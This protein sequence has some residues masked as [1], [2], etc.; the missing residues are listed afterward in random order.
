MDAP[1]FRKGERVLVLWDPTREWKQAIITGIDGKKSSGE[2]QYRI[3]YSE[4]NYEKRIPESKIRSI[5][6]YEEDSEGEDTIGGA[7]TSI[8]T[9]PPPVSLTPKHII[10]EMMTGERKTAKETKTRKRKHA[11]PHKK[12]R[13]SPS[14][15]ASPCSKQR[16]RFANV[17]SSMILNEEIQ[18]KK[19][20]QPKKRARPNLV[21]SE[22]ISDSKEDPEICVIA[23]NEDDHNS[24][25][26]V[27]DGSEDNDD[28]DRNVRVNTDSKDFVELPLRKVVKSIPYKWALKLKTIL[29]DEQKIEGRLMEMAAK[30]SFDY[31]GKEIVA[32]RQLT[33][34]VLF[35]S[36]LLKHL[37]I[38][39][40]IDFVQISQAGDQVIPTKRSGSDMEGKHILITEDLIDTG[41]T[42]ALMA[43]YLQ[44]KKCSSLKTACLLDKKTRR[45][46]SE[47]FQVDYVGFDCPEEPVVGYGVNFKGEY[48]CLPFV[49]IL[50]CET[51]E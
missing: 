13:N 34:C 23:D 20:E 22:N 19:T 40:R 37:T 47:P 29:F 10:K 4:V 18:T 50:K 5:Y 30:I 45:H 25:I 35:Q 49:G 31:R 15:P 33:S 8:C 16:R 26:C 42:L 41:K 21:Q 36:N 39:Y 3:Y 12:N 24:D 48:T 1:V 14:S 51:L 9:P 43:K 44:A 38:P 28:D 7:F 6:E 2:W 17:A 46:S 32:I 27:I 11:T